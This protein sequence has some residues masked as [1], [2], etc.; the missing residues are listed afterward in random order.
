MFEQ[1][2]ALEDFAHNNTVRHKCVTVRIG[3]WGRAVSKTSR[4]PSGGGIT[5][6]QQYNTVSGAKSSPS[7]GSE[8]LDPSREIFGLLEPI[9]LDRETCYPAY[10]KSEEAVGRY[11]KE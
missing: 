3:S 7:S 8:P 4:Q 1:L 5:C 10:V 9:A 11:V 6:V 2:W